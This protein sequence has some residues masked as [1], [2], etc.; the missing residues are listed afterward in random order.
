MTYLLLLVIFGAGVTFM[1]AAGLWLATAIA[2]YIARRGDSNN[3]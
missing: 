3:D 1:A 2:G